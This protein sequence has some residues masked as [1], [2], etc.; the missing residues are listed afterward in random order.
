MYVCFGIKHTEN[1]T[2][3]AH[4]ARLVP[5]SAG[6]NIEIGWISGRP[7]ASVPGGLAA[8]CR[9]FGPSIFAKWRQLSAKPQVYASTALWFQ[10][11]PAHPRMMLISVLMLVHPRSQQQPW[12]VCRAS[13]STQLGFSKEELRFGEMTDPGLGPGL[14]TQNINALV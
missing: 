12:E 13:V 8:G 1:K 3:P 6:E 4:P 10:N 14:L 11:N 7:L 9:R 2:G 5:E